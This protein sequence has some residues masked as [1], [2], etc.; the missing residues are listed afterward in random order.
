MAFF[1]LRVVTMAQR[2]HGASDTTL[3]P[4]KMQKFLHWLARTG[5]V[6]KAAE[7]AK[8]NRTHMYEVRKSDSAFAAAWDEALEVAVE[9]LEMEA[10]RRAEQGVL[11]P[12]YYQGVKVGAVRRYSDTLLI[13]LLKAHRPEKYR[14]HA[15]VELTGKDGGPLQAQTT[16]TVYIPDNGRGDGCSAPRS[17]RAEPA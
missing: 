17:A 6:T 14:D 10:R 2:Q 9:R 13:F 12:V 3:T 16:V 11:E 7:K 4:Q 15:S 1:V 8:V 5:N